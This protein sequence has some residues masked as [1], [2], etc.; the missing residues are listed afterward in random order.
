MKRIL[1]PLL[2]CMTTVS[3]DPFAYVTDYLGAEI[4]ILDLGT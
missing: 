2:A 3:A 1:A 4:S